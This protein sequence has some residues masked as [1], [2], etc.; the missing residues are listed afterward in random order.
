MISAGGVAA[1]TATAGAGV[2][3]A[4]LACNVAQVNLITTSYIWSLCLV[5]TSYIKCITSYNIYLT[6][7]I[8]I[9]SGE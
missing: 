1:G 9:I 4:I 7:V 3:A 6:V 8:S 5:T 2:P